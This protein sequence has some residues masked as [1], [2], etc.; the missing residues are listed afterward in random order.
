MH[1]HNASG[2]YAIS[3]KRTER[4]AGRKH[5]DSQLKGNAPGGG[6][7]R[8][9]ESLRA[10]G[11]RVLAAA[12]GVV[13]AAGMALGVAPAAHAEDASTV[14]L[15]TPAHKKTISGKHEDGSYTI[16][17]NVK[18]ATQSTSES[19][20]IDVVLVMDLSDSMD[21]KSGTPG[22]TRLT[23]AKDAAKHLANS[24]LTDAN[25]NLDKNQQV[26]MEIVKF[27]DDAAVQM[28]NQEKWSTSAED[29]CR[30]IDSLSTDNN[31]VGEG[32]DWDEGLKKANEEGTGR[33]NAEKYIIFLSDGKPGGTNSPYFENLAY[34]SALTES[35]KRNGAEL[36]V[37]STAKESAG[38]MRQLADETNPKGKYFDG[39]DE[40]SISKA[41]D[42]I[43]Q[44]ITKSYAYKNVSITDALS[45]YVDFAGVTND[46]PK[47]LKATVTKDGQETVIPNPDVKLNKTDKTITWNLGSNVALEKDA[48][49]TISFDVVPN[50]SAYNEAAARGANG[51]LNLPSN[52]T[53][54]TKVTYDVVKSETNMGDEVI[55]SKKSSVYKEEPT[56]NVPYAE[57]NLVKQWQDNALVEHGDSVKVTLK[58]DANGGHEQ[59]VT[60]E[61]NKGWESSANIPA[62]VSDAT[63]TVEEEAV[64]GY[65]PTIENE[66]FA[67]SGGVAKQS[68]DVNIEN[69]VNVG[70]VS[71]T[72]QVE[73][74]DGLT[75]PGATFKFKVTFDTE[76]G[77]LSGDYTVVKSD[78]SQPSKVANGDTITLKAGQTATIK[79]LPAGA[80][81]TAKETD[82]PQG[83]SAKD[84]QLQQNAEVVAN[85]TKPLTFTNVYG[86]GEEMAATTNV[87][88]TKELKG[89]DLQEGQFTFNI[90]PD[91][92]LA[93]DAVVTATNGKPNDKG[94]ADTTLLLHYTLADLKKAYDA[95]YAKVDT[96]NNG[97]RVWTVNYVLSEDTTLFPKGVSV[98]SPKD[99]SYK[100]TVTVTDNMKGRLTAEVNYPKNAS[101]FDFVN[102]YSTQEGGASVDTSANNLFTK[103]LIGRVWAEDDAFSFKLTPVNGAPMPEGSNGQLIAQATKPTTGDTASFGFGELTFTDADMNNATPDGEGNRV[104]EF[105]YEV[106]EL[107]DGEH[108][109][110][111]GVTQVNPNKKATLTVTVTDNLKGEL[112]AVASVD[113]GAFENK[114][115][116]VKLGADSGISIKKTLEGR[117]LIDNQFEYTVTADTDTAKKLGISENQT[118]KSGEV[119]ATG[120]A[121]KSLLFGNNV[122]FTSADVNETYTVTI[123]EGQNAKPGYTHD[124]AEWSVTYQTSIVDNVLTVTV[125]TKK[126]DEPQGQPIVIKSTDESKTAT[127]TVS[128]TNKYEAGEATLGEKGTATIAAVK[129]LANR[130]L[131]GNDF[132]FHVA[133]TADNK[134]VASGTNDK[135]G[136]ITFGDITYTTE[137]LRKD[138]GTLAQ[139]SFKDGVATYTY[140]YNV[141]EDTTGLDASGIQAVDKSFPVTVVVTDKGDG[142]KLGI[143]VQ[144]PDNSKGQ[145]TFVNTYGNTE[146]GT[147]ELAISGVKRIV[148][149]SGNNAPS[150]DD[151]AEKYT[152]TLTGSEGAPMPAGGNTAHN[153]A[154]GS[155]SFGD[156]KFTM[157]NVFGDTGNA[158]AQAEDGSQAEPVKRTKEFT[159][160]VT[161]SGNVAGVAND[162][163]KQFKVTVTDNGDGTIAVTPSETSTLFAFTNTYSAAPATV[164]NLASG[165]KV[166][167]GRALNADEFAFQL[168]DSAGNVL[169]QTTNKADGSFAFE[170]MTYSA[171]G[172][173]VYTVSE[174]DGA[175]G[176]VTYDPAVYTVVVDVTDNGAGQLEA[177]VS[178]QQDKKPVD[179]LV[180]TNTYAY[181]E[182]GVPFQ[183]IAHKE[184]NGRELKAGEFSFEL[185]QTGTKN[186]KSWTAKNVEDGSIVFPTLTFKAP[187]KY[188]FVISEIKGDDKTIEYDKN[189]YKMSVEVTDTGKGYLTAQATFPGGK[190]PVFQNTYTKPAEPA[191]TGKTEAKGPE[192][193]QTG[194]SS[195]LGVVVAVVAGVA[196]IGGGAVL[197]SK[198]IRR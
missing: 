77:E 67:V 3:C 181:D 191:D 30:A 51:S 140:Q 46:K 43:V 84:N 36:F 19:K 167:E 92:T 194:D 31:G 178:Y 1:R 96:N 18:G 4:R 12:F 27:A 105:K 100:F 69:K 142:S 6:A 56:I 102:K 16:S 80:A 157:A 34:Q 165:R 121:T 159:Y 107:V 111:A 151:I 54:N 49:Y 114:Y 147:A 168:K 185:K 124:K 197:L 118:V 125:T 128:F 90:K 132:T 172:Q 47:N 117:D 39:A 60:L 112:K 20:P 166:L 44:T 101:T 62:G 110:P 24:L 74:A 136:D 95:G 52:D 72:K 139:Y 21:W 68:I 66:N 123:K 158:V 177:K 155:I 93:T 120:K 50:Q 163:E 91:T 17:L 59:V 64:A 94:I 152:F 9:R 78:D 70:D 106:V 32:T 180:F 7:S 65:T 38:R 85:E 134:V 164:S 150:L 144:Y 184:L 175:M 81:V 11:Q 48:I 88:V 14:D 135:N 109:L 113:N 28:V 146:K 98:E 174:V 87:T 76:N 196:C 15:G 173:Y 183:L 22:K 61:K 75:A 35:K 198:R 119:D 170:G 82:M 79:G 179:E 116:D 53:D 143:N 10:G 187:G 189:D 182:A 169:Q 97:E 131:A 126:G 130:P 25:Q 138:K 133:N 41:F 115:E 40:D 99:G 26:K 63:W 55:E 58:T 153:D 13:L 171:P 29:V 45:E 127:A 162:G 156:I 8:Y 23:I 195:M 2:A 37:V 129:K 5:H 141:Y 192:L 108:Q 73:S 193:P 33:P 161:E 137:Q 71:I 122:T 190:P 176:G 145:L 89:L 103:K 42:S 148:A 57:V 160:T 154:T 86:N 188:D 104:K 83:F 149:Q 186:N